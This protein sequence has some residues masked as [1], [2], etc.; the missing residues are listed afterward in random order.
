VRFD[1]E[2]HRTPGQ[3]FSTL[4][5]RVDPEMTR[6]LRMVQHLLRLGRLERSI[7]R[8][9]R[10]G[11]RA[12]HRLGLQRVQHAVA[13]LPMRRYLIT[14][15]F[16]RGGI[17]RSRVGA[18][19]PNASTRLSTSRTSGAMSRS[20]PNVGRARRSTG[21][22]TT[23]LMPSTSS[24]RMADFLCQRRARLRRFAHDGGTAAQLGVPERTE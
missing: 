3:P 15:V 19:I 18:S 14:D 5:K 11:D 12:R 20:N 9:P 16:R 8:R 24:T 17:A 1:Q 7:T 6:R 2:H 23:L 21:N 22:R 13:L 4:A 10:R